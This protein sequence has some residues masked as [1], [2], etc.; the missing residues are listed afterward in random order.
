MQKCNTDFGLKVN[1]ITF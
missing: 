1:L